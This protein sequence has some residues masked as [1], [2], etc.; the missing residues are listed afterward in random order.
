MAEV[1]HIQ[2]IWPR[3]KKCKNRVRYLGGIFL[4]IRRYFAGI[5]AKTGIAT[6]AVKNLVRNPYYFNTDKDRRLRL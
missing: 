2:E 5:V 1:F 4:E 3:Y 6:D